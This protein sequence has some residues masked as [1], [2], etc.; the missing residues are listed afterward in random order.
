MSLTGALA[1]P[2]GRRETLR[3]GAWPALYPL[4]P[5]DRALL[6]EG[7]AQA[8]AEEARAIALYRAER[9]LAELRELAATMPAGPGLEATR[10]RMA[11]LGDL[12]EAP[13]PDAGPAVVSDLATLRQAAR[14][15]QAGAARLLGVDRRWL[16]AVESGGRHP[17]AQLL[18]A[19]L[20]LYGEQAE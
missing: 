15:S 1:R 20:E 9:E 17:S 14:L 7:E 2:V 11:E 3:R 19:M 6:A 18:A 4:S 8:A 10:R 5:F 12:L 16:W 13:P